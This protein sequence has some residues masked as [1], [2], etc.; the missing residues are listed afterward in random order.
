[1]GGTDRFNNDSLYQ[2]KHASSKD[3]DYIKEI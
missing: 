3:I 1:M 2:Q